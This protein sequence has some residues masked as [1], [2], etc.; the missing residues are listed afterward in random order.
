MSQIDEAQK[1]LY[2]VMYWSVY[3]AVAASVLLTFDSTKFPSVQLKDRSND[4]RL[5]I[6]NHRCVLRRRGSRRKAGG[7]Y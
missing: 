3:L 6:C 7:I 5:Q 4:L 2:T 1:E